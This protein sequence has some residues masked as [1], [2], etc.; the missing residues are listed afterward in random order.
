MSETPPPAPDP[1]SDPGEAAAADAGVMATTYDLLQGRLRTVAGQRSDAA[2]ALNAARAQVFASEGLRLTEQ[3]RLHTAEASHP[4]DVVSVG[5]MLLFGYNI[6]PGLAAKRA[7][8]DVFTLHHLANNSPSDIDFAPIDPDDP[9]LFLAD[10]SFRRDF[11]ELY[12]YYAD[13]RLQSLRTTPTLLLMVFTIGD[14]EHDLRVL[15]WRLDPSGPVYVDAYGEHDLV[16]PQQYDFTW[17]TIDRTELTE[18]RWQHW[19]LDDLVFLGGQAGHLEFRVDDAVE[20][21]KV[22]H[23]EVLAASEGAISELQIATARL[24]ELLLIRLL[25]Y[26]ETAER[27]YVYNRL[28][29]VVHRID[30]LG[31][32]CHRLPED[33][34]IIFP[35]GFHLQN[36]ETKVF[37]TDA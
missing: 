32:N 37:A 2:D 4:C 1:A 21:G 27:F 22:V 35:G 33:S 26:R 23:R 20:N 29:R 7:V 10:P 34:G 6:P 8:G 15:R 17:N 16:A 5:D 30:A 14:G 13:C 18:G 9:S 12:T 19:N 28:T 11:D 31:L 3:D 24:G 25:P 36:G